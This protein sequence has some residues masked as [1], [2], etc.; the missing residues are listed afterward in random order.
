[1][2]KD[3]NSVSINRPFYKRGFSCPGNSD[4]NV[5]RDG[6]GDSLEISSQSHGIGFGKPSLRRG[7]SCP[8]GDGYNKIERQEIKTVTGG[9]GS[10]SS[11]DW[12]R[13]TG[14]SGGFGKPSCEANSSQNS[15]CDRRNWFNKA[16]EN[17]DSQNN[18]QNGFILQN[19]FGTPNKTDDYHQGLQRKGF[20][21]PNDVTLFNN[22]QASEKMEEVWKV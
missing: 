7:F 6:A 3:R 21:S 14:F 17:R 8:S 4:S 18:N 20:G 11:V 12:D 22:N 13:N 9:F 16:F 19:G 1:M 10:R 2:R 15:V 5:E